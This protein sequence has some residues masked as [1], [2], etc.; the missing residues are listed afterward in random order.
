MSFDKFL[1]VKLKCDQLFHCAQACVEPMAFPCHSQLQCQHQTLVT[2]QHHVIARVVLSQW[3]GYICASKKAIHKICAKIFFALAHPC[4]YNSTPL[5][6][7]IHKSTPFHKLTIPTPFMAIQFSQ[8]S[9]WM[10]QLWANF[11]PFNS[12]FQ[13]PAI[14]SQS[15][16]TLWGSSF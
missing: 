8:N 2:R 6:G 14:C 1:H 13:C 11:V 16:Y 15:Y 5:H 3:R 7:C 12:H 10:D 4:I 9:K